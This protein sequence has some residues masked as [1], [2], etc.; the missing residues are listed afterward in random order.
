MKLS[1]KL[2]IWKFQFETNQICYQDFSEKREDSDSHQLGGVCK[3]FYLALP[4]SLKTLTELSEIN[5]VSF[6]V[7]NFQ[8]NWFSSH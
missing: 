8:L 5:A 2:L 6:A 4:S 7:E 3:L 1:L